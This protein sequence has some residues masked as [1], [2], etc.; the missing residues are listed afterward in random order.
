[1][2]GFV[3]PAGQGREGKDMDDPIEDFRRQRRRTFYPKTDSELPDDVLRSRPGPMCVS[4]GVVADLC[5]EA[6][7]VNAVAVTPIEPQGTFHHLARVA[8]G[9]GRRVVVRV[10][11]MRGHVR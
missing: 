5:R 1:M 8:L 9:D 10:N 3:G 11:A 2:P 4:P 7:G 6:L